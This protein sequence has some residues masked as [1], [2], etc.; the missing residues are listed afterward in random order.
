MNAATELPR[1]GGDLTKAW[2]ESV[3]N[4]GSDVIRIA[5]VVLAPIGEGAGMM[6]NLFRASLTYAEGSGPASV[7]V[8]LPT[9][10]EQNREVARAFDNYRREV[11]FYRRAAHAT[12]MRTAEVYL[13]RAD[14]P[15]DFVLV[16]ED[17][18]AWEQ[19]DQVAGCSLPRAEAV[20]D[21]LADLH[22]AFWE[23][24]DGGEMDWLPHSHPSVMSD[25]LAAGTEANYEQ[26]ARFFADDIA[27]ELRQAK[28]R[29]MAGLP[30]VQAWINASPRT[31]IHGDFRMDNLFFRPHAGGIEV[32]CCDWQAPV[33]GKG[34]QDIAYFLSGSVE[35]AM[36]RAH[37]QA[38]IARWVNALRARGV[39]D[40]GE[41]QAFED[42]RRAIL[43][44]WTY[45]VIIGGG[46]AAQNARA[47]NWVTA[48]VRRSAAAMMDHDCLSML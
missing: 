14:S 38:L 8:K 24:V 11:E 15:T 12:P 43:M 6:S 21:A 25:G 44:L 30:A 29:Y 48:M 41:D 3:L 45:T 42:Y 1:S 39:R 5:S 17:L 34:V 4:S 10:N 26:F 40:Y 19:G 35:T 16:L 22:A 32:A 2:F 18:S 47:E 23:Q 46:L 31:V 27:P 9:H 37:E 28:A 33:R 20:M 13:A 36:R 7:V